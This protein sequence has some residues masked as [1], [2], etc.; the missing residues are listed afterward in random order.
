MNGFSSG[1][2]HWL[3]SHCVL[4]QTHPRVCVSLVSLL[5][6]K[7]TPVILAG[8]QPIWPQ[9]NLEPLSPNTV[10]LWVKPL[11]YE[12]WGDT[13]QA[14][15]TVHF[16]W[17]MAWHIVFIGLTLECVPF[18]LVHS[19]NPQSLKLYFTIVVTSVR[20]KGVQL[21]NVVALKVSGSFTKYFNLIY[22]EYFI[23]I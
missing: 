19:F 3:L 9:G 16:S 11:R 1:F 6:L 23:I 7:R 4:M 8:A 17:E 21:V 10:T 2:S 5:Y 12:F 20:V 18:F 22:L 15:T 13:F 14:L